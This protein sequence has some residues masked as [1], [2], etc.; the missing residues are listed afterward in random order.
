MRAGVTAAVVNA[1]DY[2]ISYRYGNELI[3][4]RERMLTM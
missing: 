2:S 3:D 4:S 1:A